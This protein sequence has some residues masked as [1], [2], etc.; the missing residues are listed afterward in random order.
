MRS[1]SRLMRVL[2]QLVVKSPGW[3]FAMR[4]ARRP[5][6][7]TYDLDADLIELSATSALSGAPQI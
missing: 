1:L 6:A 4:L 7:G 5:R 2:L 3:L